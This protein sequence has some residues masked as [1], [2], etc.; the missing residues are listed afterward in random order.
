MARFGPIYLWPWGPVR[1]GQTFNSLPFASISFHSLSSTRGKDASLGV[2][3]NDVCEQCS[4]QRGYGVR[5]SCRWFGVGRGPSPRASTPCSSRRRRS[6]GPCRQPSE[7][8]ARVAVKIS[9]ALATKQWSPKAMCGYGR[10]GC[11]VAS[12]GC[13]LFSGV[14]FGGFKPLSQKRRSTPQP[15]FQDSRLGP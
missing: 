13:S 5:G 6:G 10:S 4:N 14:G 1:S 12:L 11:V 2:G 8:R 7:R 15:L 9:P 3:R